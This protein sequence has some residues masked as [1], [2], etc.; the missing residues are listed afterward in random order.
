[1]SFFKPVIAK[2]DKFE[3]KN[4]TFTQ[5]NLGG[6]GGGAESAYRTVPCSVV[7]KQ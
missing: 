4:V 1:M 7:L 5:I 6:G 2:H 3:K